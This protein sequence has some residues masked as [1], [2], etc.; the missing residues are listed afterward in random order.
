MKYMTRW[1]SNGKN[2]H[3]METV[4]ELISQLY[5]FDGIMEFW[6]AYCKVCKKE[7]DNIMQKYRYKLL[8]HANNED[9]MNNWDILGISYELIDPLGCA[10]SDGIKHKDIHIEL[11]VKKYL[12][13]QY[14]HAVMF[15]KEKEVVTQKGR[16][17]D[18][19]K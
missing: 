14:E 18:F 13:Q 2:T 3:T 6:Y 11:D 8:E 19:E 1:E 9:L 17:L 4:W 7:V 16:S 12:A 10:I 5:P 15:H